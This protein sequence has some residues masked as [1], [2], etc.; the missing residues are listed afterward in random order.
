MNIL[1]L[2]K[3]NPYS[4]DKIEKDKIFLELFKNLNDYH[5]NNCKVY[6]KIFNTIKENKPNL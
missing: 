5:L 1:D 6:K 2:A 4:L 3:I